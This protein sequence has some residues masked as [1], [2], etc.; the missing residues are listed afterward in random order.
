MGCAR[1]QFNSEYPDLIGEN[2]H[3]PVPLGLPRTRC[4]FRVRRFLSTP[5]IEY[6]WFS[7]D[8]LS[9]MDRFLRRYLYLGLFLFAVLVFLVHY[10]VSGQAVY[11]D[12][13]GYYSHLHSWVIDGDW[14]YTNEYRHIYD[15]QHNN[16]DTGIESPVV[17]IVGTTETGKAENFYGTGVAVLLLPFYLLA[18]LISNLANLFGAGF[19]VQ[20]Y[21]DIYQVL[22]GIGA[23]IYTVWGVYF[24]N[25][26]I[27]FVIKDKKISLIS[28]VAIFLSTS[29][30]YY[31][32]FDVINSHFASFFLTAVFF[33]LFMAKK[34][35]LLLGLVAGLLT[36]N[37]VQDSV[38]VL[39]WLVDVLIKKDLLKSVKGFF[40]GFVFAIIPLIFHWSSVISDLFNHP[41]L[42]G[43]SERFGGEQSV[44]ISGSL[45]SPIT[46]L[47]FRTPVLL[48]VLI[49]FLYLVWKRD[50]KNLIYPL[51]FFLMQYVIITAQGGWEAAAYG[52]RMYISSLVFFGPVLGKFLLQMSKKSWVAVYLFVAI[53]ILINFFSMAVFILRDKGAEGGIHGTEQRTIQRVEKYFK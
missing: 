20:G 2:I 19:S 42:R 40:V 52:G 11:G 38:V 5:T 32:S 8:I 18:H 14:D 48:V 13:I 17:Q 34:N 15:S 26:I 23:I 6:F 12:G 16:I 43:L 29:L 24:L 7:L 4:G 36:L 30:L 31:G 47:F 28:S 46:G 33:Y 41:Y 25:K 53:F 9:E 44:D 50:T 45:F 1:S 35:N 37:R 27:N 39:I 21:G 49:F 3:S 10:A 22:T 51:A